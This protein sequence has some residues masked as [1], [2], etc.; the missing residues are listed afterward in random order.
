MRIL[1]SV[2][3]LMIGWK[4]HLSMKME[5]DKEL[6]QDGK[7]GNVL[8]TYEDRPMQWDNWDIDVFYQRKPYEA[9]WYSP[10]RI[11]ESGDVCIVLEFS[12]GFVDSVVTQRVCLYHHLPR[13]DFRTKADWKTHHVLLKAQFSC[14]CERHKG[15]I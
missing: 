5:A 14:G 11:V 7:C 3:V 9:D 2:S 1:F 8:R 15:N 12:C 6:I 4:S 10:V 13:I